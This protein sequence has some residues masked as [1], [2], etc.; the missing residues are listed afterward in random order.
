MNP[1][2]TESRK[3][4]SW[5][6]G[7][8]FCLLAALGIT[9]WGLRIPLYK[10]S[11]YGDSGHLVFSYGEHL[12]LHFTEYLP[13]RAAP[14][15]TVRD[16]QAAHRPI[17]RDAITVLLRLFGEEHVPIIST[18]LAIHICNA[19]LCFI[20][21][22]VFSRQIPSAAAGAVVFLTSVNAF[23]PIY[24][25]AAIFDLITTTFALASALCL[26]LALYG[27]T[28]R[29]L[30]LL[31]NLVF[32]LFAVKT[33]ESS[34]VLIVPLSFIVLSYL[35][36]NVTTAESASRVSAK[37]RLEWL[38][39][40]LRYVPRSLA[41]WYLSLLALGAILA[42]NVVTDF[43][44][45]TEFSSTAYARDYSLN[46][47]FT[48]FG[49][50]LANYIY[51]A[52]TPAPIPAALAFVIIVA[53]TAAALY[54]R[55]LLMSVGL[56]WWFSL[57]GVLATITQRYT[58]PHYPYPAT[59]GGAMYVAGLLAEL[60]IRFSHERS[61]KAVVLLL[62]AGTICLTSVLSYRWVRT[63]I[64]P[65][66]TMAF[67]ELSTKTYDSLKATVRQ[68]PH[69]SEFIIVTE[70]F[71]FLD[72]G[73]TT[74]LKAVYH[75]LTLEGR[76]FKTEAD[77]QTDFDQATGPNRYLLAM[78]DGHFKLLSKVRDNVIT[79]P[80]EASKDARGN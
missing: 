5:S 48:S 21:I 70:T 31:L 64:L 58:D 33:K 53:L 76:L 24:W 22:F 80:R 55:S 41:C 26:V 1:P 39:K 30:L 71:T 34:L 18:L 17:G 37:V 29:R 63:A 79:T 72:Q 9:I 20:L 73:P 46:A 27:D 44:G 36:R 67:Y 75:D 50:Y 28:K 52:H 43:R 61:R 12:R 16:I 56:V 78:K 13:W 45:A 23:S 54:S 7:F 77:G 65:T 62:S 69:G 8:V 32:F 14:L 40:L 57:L 51:V 2:A 25:P 35:A 19:F 11:L 74:A 4:V 68:P 3:R 38:G 10:G 59:V 6:F 42:I 66:W 60:S 49:L 47:I 15:Q